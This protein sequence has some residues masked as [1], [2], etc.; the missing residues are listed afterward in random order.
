MALGD[1][2]NIF[3]DVKSK[4]SITVSEKI[5]IINLF[6]G[7]KNVSIKVSYPGENTGRRANGY[8]NI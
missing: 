2:R 7:L 4:P 5:D 8:V 1:F 3:E 6:D